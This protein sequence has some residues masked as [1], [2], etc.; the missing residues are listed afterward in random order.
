M[1]ASVLLQWLKKIYIAL[2]QNLI[3]RCVTIKDGTLIHVQTLTLLALN[4]VS[5][6]VFFFVCLMVFNA[7]FSNISVILWRLVVLV[8]ETGWP[9]ENHRTV[10]SN[11][12]TLSHNVVH[13][14][15]IEIRWYALIAYVVV[16]PTTIRSQPRRHSNAVSNL[17]V[18]YN[19]I[20]YTRIIP[21]TAKSSDQTVVC[22]WY[23]TNIILIGRSIVWIIK[24]VLKR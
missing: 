9:G 6:F 19:I 8:E 1:S 15:L 21:P 22:I 7:T 16:N 10:V 14:A 12:Q 13:L 18:L 11:W 17:H 20:S 24:M 23:N 3:F 2:E 5:I 4:A